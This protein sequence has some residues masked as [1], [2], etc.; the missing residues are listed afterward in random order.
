MGGRLGLIYR[1]LFGFVLL[2]VLAGVAI[3]ALSNVT[4]RFVDETSAN[5][6]ESK[7][8]AE[9]SKSAVDKAMARLRAEEEIFARERLESRT[10]TLAHMVEL[11]LVADPDA[12][13]GVS[14]DLERLLVEERFDHFGEEAWFLVVDGRTGVVRLHRD[15]ALRGK[16][17]GELDAALWAW[18]SGEG[19]AARLL[20]G[21]A[22]PVPAPKAPAGVAAVPGAAVPAELAG[23]GVEVK[24]YTDA[25]GRASIWLAA[26]VGHTDNLLVV[27]SPLDDTPEVKLVEVRT[28]LEKEVGDAASAIG[29]RSAEVLSF[30]ERARS[31]IANIQIGVFLALVAGVLLFGFYVNRRFIKPVQHLKS[32]ADHIRAGEFDTRARVFTADELEQLGRSLNEMLDRIVMLIQSDEDKRRLQRNIVALLELVSAASDGDLT[33]RGEVTPDEL[34]SVTDAFNLML[35]SIGSL[36]VQARRAAEEV[37]RSASGLKSAADEMAEG[38]KLQA[39]SIDSTTRKIKT[40]GEKSLEV[41]AIVEMVDDIAAQTNMLALNAAIE[42]SR[43]GEQGKGFAVVADE[44][45]KL[46]ERSSNATRAIGA[47]IESI[48]VEMDEAARA[49]E[50]IRA[51]TRKTADSAASTRTTVEAMVRLALALEQTLS[52]FRVHDAREEEMLQNLEARRAAIEEA[53]EAIASFAGGAGAASLGVGDAAD[54]TLQ[55][56]MERLTETR[57]RLVTER[58]RLALRAAGTGSGPV[59]AA[60]DGDGDGGGGGEDGDVES[61]PRGAEETH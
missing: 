38:A 45:R 51:V 54:Q 31:D 25:V 57:E 14:E 48:Q 21:S 29:L 55:E 50:E 17:A 26:R 16:A 23:G 37:S 44:V 43:A 18:L 36:V 15:A 20:A 11:A 1:F 40:L 49:M 12:L 9:T 4:G 52:R 33:A 60:G 58:G 5:V 32:V 42:A 8:R 3:V 35:E 7:A 39:E 56:L 53:L 46:A 22:V 59:P 28:Q 19:A 61:G 6:S 13:R 34:G 10:R 2:A 27:H 41:N 24:T 30:A 47:F